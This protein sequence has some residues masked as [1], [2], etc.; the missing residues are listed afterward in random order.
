MKKNPNLFARK[1]LLALAVPMLMFGQAQA[2]EFEFGE[3]SLTVDTQLSIGS[4]WR[5]EDQNENL[6]NYAKADPAPADGSTADDGNRNYK[7]GDAFSQI[8]KGSHDLQLTYQNYGAFVRAKYWYDSAIENNSV[9]HGHAPTYI[10]GSITAKSFPGKSKL[11]DSGF[12]DLHKGSGI[13]LLDA[14]VYG[15]FDIGEMPL[16]LRL[17]KQVVSWGESTFIGGGINQINPVD[18]AAFRRPGA[19]IKEGLLPVNMV[20]ANLGLTESLSLEA[21]YQLEFQETLPDSCGTYFS[22]S[23]VFAEGCNTLTASGGAVSTSRDETN[24]IRRASDDGQFGI[25]LRY[26]SDALDTE[27]GFYAMNIHERLGMYG[28]VLDTTD[29]LAFG[30]SVIYAGFQDP[31]GEAG[32]PFPGLTVE[33]LFDGSYSA[34]LTAAANAAY[35]ASAA[36]LAVAGR[37]TTA[38][39]FFEYP[40]DK[41][42]LGLSFAGNAYGVAISGEVSHQI[43]APIAINGNLATGAQLARGLAAD[44]GTGKQDAFAAYVN[45]AGQG[46]SVSGYRLFDITQVQATAIHLENRL[47]GASSMTFLAEVGVTFIDGIEDDVLLYGRS[48]TYGDPSY[49]DEDDGFVTDVSWGYRA[50]A[51]AKYTNAFAGVD[52]N[53]TVVFTHDVEGYGP[54]FNEEAKTLAVSLKANYLQRYDASISYKAFMGGDYNIFKDRDFLAISAGVQF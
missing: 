15:S 50:L 27:F 12:N 28:T 39:Y 37:T 23:D 2:V 6:L 49:T 40:E 24:G 13:S 16:D 4:S 38:R 36:D 1:K 8:F 29:D 17:G 25:A 22:P 43:D 3:A 53:P 42:I 48:S 9:E 44:D 47:L 46:D 19:E 5:M 7:N 10:D 52:L 14:F 31:D 34:A 54:Q 41:K 51:S 11:D 21:F 30:Q 20:Y 45:G 26:F 35:A 18:A 33:N 32:G